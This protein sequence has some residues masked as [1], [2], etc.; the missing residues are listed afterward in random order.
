MI[1]PN[2]IIE[3]FTVEELCQT[4]DDYFKSVQD[5]TPHLAKPFS[6]LRDGPV[7]LQN[8]GFLLSGLHLAKTMTV[9]DFAAGTC[10]LSRYLHQLQC[11]TISCDVSSTALEF[12]K[13]LFEEYPII[14]DPIAEPSFLHFDGHKIDLPD[15]S[16]DRIICL[17]GFH[18]VPNQEEV[19]AELARVLKRGGIAGFSEPGR[20]HSQSP[21]SQ[22]EMRN[23]AVLENDILVP[24]IFTIAQKH[25]F[26]DIRLRVLDDIEVSLN[27]YKF[28]TSQI[29]RKLLNLIYH[30][31]GNMMVN[32]TIFFLYKGDYIPD[33]RSHIGLACSLSTARNVFSIAAGESLDILVKVTNTGRAGWL[34]EN[35]NGIGVVKIG[36]H[37]YDEANH[38][39]NLDFSRHDLPEF[40]EPGTTF[41]QSI[42]VRFDDSGT[43][44]LAVDLVSE[45][46]CWFENGGSIPITVTVNVE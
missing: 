15:E 27:Q 5:S 31:V 24:E 7:I 40:I 26:T 44:K 9:L 25:G 33:S 16:V 38:L 45:S 12:G 13:Q 3:K 42:K 36:T 41:E 20:F 46:I 39:L 21:Q 18:H 1:K 23:Y 19:I 11:K 14:G 34:T 32:R 8:L 29:T 2:D 28:L 4:A 35:I 22:F 17:A 6:S 30:D 37:L 10:W 43:Y